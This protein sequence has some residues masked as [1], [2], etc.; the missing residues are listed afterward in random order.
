MAGLSFE[1]NGL[2]FGSNARAS[3]NRHP[4]AVVKLQYTEPDR[5]GR[6]PLLSEYPR[7][8]APTKQVSLCVEV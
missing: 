2:L 7:R 1:K 6:R 8:S 5:V 4:A 3:M